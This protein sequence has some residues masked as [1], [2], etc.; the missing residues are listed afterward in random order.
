MKR[1]TFLKGLISLPLITIP[2][3]VLA[4]RTVDLA[5]KVPEKFLYVEVSARRAGKTTRLVNHMINYIDKT[6]NKVYFASGNHHMTYYVKNQY[7]PKKYYKYILDM[8]R[9]QDKDYEILMAYYDDPEVYAKSMKYNDMVIFL[10]NA[11]YA[12]TPHS[13]T[14]ILKYV[15][16]R[17][18]RVYRYKPYCYEAD[19]QFWDIELKN[20]LTTSE[21]NREVLGLWE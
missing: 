2:N 6:G 21:Y 14:G 4:N 10:D 1:R 5:K 17:A 9:T 7:I 3:I 11:Y 12:G 18:D 8:P 15:A 20:K 19:K 13:S 16:D